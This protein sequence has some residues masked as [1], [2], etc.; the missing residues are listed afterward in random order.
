MAVISFGSAST[1]ETGQRRRN[2]CSLPLHYI[3]ILGIIVII[4]LILM[5]YLTLCVNIPTHHWQWLSIVI[6]SIIIL[7]FLIA[8]IIITF[9]G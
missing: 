3:Q 4:F 5:N 8:F 7:P 2:A 9:F 1:L 6:S